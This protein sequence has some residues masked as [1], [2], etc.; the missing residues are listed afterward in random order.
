[1]GRPGGGVRQ[2]HRDLIQFLVLRSPRHGEHSAGDDDS[3]SRALLVRADLLGIDGIE[4]G[5]DDESAR[6]DCDRGN[7]RPVPRLLLV[8]GCPD[9]RGELRRQRHEGGGG[10]PAL[11][12]HPRPPVPQPERERDREGRPDRDERQ[13][14]DPEGD[15]DAR[16]DGTG[17]GGEPRQ[18]EEQ[19]C[20]DDEE[21]QD[22]HE[23]GQR[24]AVRDRVVARQDVPEDG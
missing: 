4:P 6:G 22:G 1:M 24:T 8:L 14:R 13:V 15:G 19:D 23:H 17:Q 2:L 20:G 3:T 10:D 12:Q 21:W 16:G 11:T 18:E 9:H 5:T 7:G